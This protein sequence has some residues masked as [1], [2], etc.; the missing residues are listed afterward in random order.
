MAALFFKVFCI[1]I[2]SSFFRGV[3]AYKGNNV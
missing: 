1:I 2:V 3:F